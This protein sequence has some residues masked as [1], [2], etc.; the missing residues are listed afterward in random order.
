M[1]IAK[2]KNKKIKLLF[3]SQWL[4]ISMCSVVVK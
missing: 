2:K 4:F 3:V 1:V